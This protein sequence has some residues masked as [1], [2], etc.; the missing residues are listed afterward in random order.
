MHNDIYRKIRPKWSNSYLLVFKFSLIYAMCDFIVNKN[1][2]VDKLLITMFYSLQDTV[3]F[4]S[5]PLLH[6][7][8]FKF[9]QCVHREWRI[10]TTAKFGKDNF[11]L[12]WQNENSENSTSRWNLF[13][14]LADSL[15]FIL[16][17]LNFTAGWRLKAAIWQRGLDR[18]K[19]RWCHKQ[20]EPWHSRH[21]MSQHLFHREK[22]RA[23]NKERDTKKQTGDGHRGWILCLH[24]AKRLKLN[25]LCHSVCLQINECV[26]K[27]VTGNE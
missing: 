23:K 22:K 16:N 19:Q 11:S 3:F 18:S 21:F 8:K 4:H 9:S 13:V 27:Y 17:V 25:L 26:S 20:L 7:P 12:C 5:R 15:V 1:T 14:H 2:A 10:E 24:T 6:W